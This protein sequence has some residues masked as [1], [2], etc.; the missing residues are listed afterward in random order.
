MPLIPPRSAGF[1]YGLWGTLLTAY[2][3]ALGGLI[4]YLGALLH[5]GGLVL[6]GCVTRGLIDY[7]GAHGPGSLWL[8]VLLPAAAGGVRPHSRV[9]RA[10]LN[11]RYSASL[12]PQACAA[13]WSFAS[14]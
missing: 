12:L 6:V 9:L 5:L 8:L 1:W 4:D 2:G 7:L 10:A 13:P 3:F 14:C 11:V